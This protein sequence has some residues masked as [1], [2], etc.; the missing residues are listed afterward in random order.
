MI[1]YY[2]FINVGFKGIIFYIESEVF[3][4]VLE[5]G[6]YLISFFGYFFRIYKNIIIIGILV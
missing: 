2:C 6:F 1:K 5:V 4:L 3:F